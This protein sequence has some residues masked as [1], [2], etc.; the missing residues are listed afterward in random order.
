M[1]CHTSGIGRGLR[2]EHDSHETLEFFHL[3]SLRKSG[4]LSTE[5]KGAFTYYSFSEST[6]IDLLISLCGV[7]PKGKIKE[8]VN[9]V[10]PPIGFL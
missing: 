7:P 2:D 3:R 9:F 1:F 5:R 8:K 10:Y 4:I 6:L